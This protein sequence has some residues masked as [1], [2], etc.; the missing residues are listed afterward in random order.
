[1]QDYYYGAH[2]TA[3]SDWDESELKT[4]LVEHG[5]IKSNAQVQKEKLQKL[6]ADN[7]ATAHDTVYGG[8][9]DSDMRQWLIDNG[10]LRSDAQVKRDELHKLMS[11]KYTNLRDTSAAYLTWPDARLRAY[12]R[13]NGVDDKY[14][15]TTRPGLLQEVRIRYVHS[16]R[17]AATLRLTFAG[18]P[19]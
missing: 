12:I 5:I 11:D 19:L 17:L 16:H 2:D 15:P 14:I 9:R 7:Y 13:A 18:S 3:Y 8:W 4:W 10:Y 1:M 6:V